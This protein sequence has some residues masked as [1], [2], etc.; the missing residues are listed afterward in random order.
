MITVF[1]RLVT[2]I[3][4]DLSV[5]SHILLSK[6]DQAWSPSEITARS[7]AREGGWRGRTQKC[8]A[9]ARHDISGKFIVSTGQ[10]ML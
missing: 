8:R 6:D 4:T 9:L 3:T 7:A 2:M 10:E 5:M 1:A